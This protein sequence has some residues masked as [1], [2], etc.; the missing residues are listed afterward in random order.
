MKYGNL[1]QRSKFWALGAGDSAPAAVS[2]LQIDSNT[3]THPYT[4]APPCSHV[5]VLC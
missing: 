5:N 1:T 3:G 2:Q 4:Y